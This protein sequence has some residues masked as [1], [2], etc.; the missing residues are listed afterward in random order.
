MA[1]THTSE[2][3][4]ADWMRSN[5]SPCSSTVEATEERP[6]SRVRG[7]A[8]PSALIAGFLFL[9][10]FDYHALGM[11]T[12]TP[13]RILFLFIFG[14]FVVALKNGR[15]QSISM[16]GLEWT[17]LLFAALC[18]VSYIFSNPDGGQLRFKWLITL[19]N[20]IFC[21]FGIFLVARSARYDATKVRWLMWAIVCMGVY[22]AFTAVF[23][24]YRID[25]LVFPRYIVDPHVGIQFGRA[26]G[27][28][29]GS[30]P[31][32]EWLVAVYLAICLVLPSAKS[33]T[34]I[35]LN[36]LILVVIVA[37]YFTLTRGCW[38]SFAY[39]VVLTS[40]FGGKFGTPSRIIVLLVGVAFFAGVGSKFS[41][42][43]DTL[44][45]RRQN[46]IEYRM[47]NNETT[48]KMGMANFLTGVGYGKFGENWE[49]YFGSAQK[50]LTKDLTDGNHNIY[51]GLFADLGFPGV[52][53]YVTIFGFIL[54]DCVRK[55]RALDRESLF[56]RNLMLSTLGMVIIL[57]WEGMSGDM[58]FNPT[59][60][61]LTFLFTGIA[62]SIPQPLKVRRKS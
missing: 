30:N 58:R 33:F 36:G 38:L 32:G 62:A 51:L 13:D 50:E 31:M 49:K 39:V 43:G 8:L 12:V 61:T 23:E 55:F 21:P 59:L 3:S 22:L 53:L 1:Y 47:S 52:A 10:M 41:F 4:V 29:V 7:F 25:S 18:V 27:P 54:R 46:T 6:Q 20:L 35:L 14:S 45:S 9:Q 48:Y 24:H 60:N 5:A 28:M 57:L 37:I 15:A 42:S 17:M 19:F 16:S 2:P 34:K 11:S 44:F 26:R 40:L 56:E